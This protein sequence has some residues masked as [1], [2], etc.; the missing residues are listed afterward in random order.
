MNDTIVKL[1]H[2]LHATWRE[3]KEINGFHL[4]VK[5]PNFEH[6]YD[7]DLETVDEGLIHCNKCNT[8]MGDFESLEEFVKKSYYE[9]AE[10]MFEGMKE[11]DLNLS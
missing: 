6:V 8:N 5:C 4:P 9:K 2:Y 7:E 11:F 10:K 3:E 1:A